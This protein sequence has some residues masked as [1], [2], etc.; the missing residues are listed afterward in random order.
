MR[1]EMAE[2]KRKEREELAVKQAKFFKPKPKVSEW[3]CVGL[4]HY[5]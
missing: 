2:K 4:E 3:R 1:A 5:N